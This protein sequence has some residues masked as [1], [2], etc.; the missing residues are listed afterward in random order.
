MWQAPASHGTRVSTPKPGKA[1]QLL[2]WVSERLCHHQFSWP[3]I[4]AHGRDYQVCVLCGTAYEYD[5]SS[6]RR[7]RRVGAAR[8]A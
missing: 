5:W 2:A 7:T 8:E 3:H 1:A 4:G 6:M